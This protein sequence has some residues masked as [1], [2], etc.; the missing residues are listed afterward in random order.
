MDTQAQV[1]VLDDKINVRQRL[2][3]LADWQGAWK[4]QVA[5]LDQKIAAMGDMP[6]AIDIQKAVQIDSL[7][8]QIELQQVKI[9]LEISPEVI[10]A[11]GYSKLRQHLV[12]Q[13]TQL[14]KEERLF[15]LNNFLFI[16]TPQLRQLNIKIVQIRNYRSFGQQRNFLLGGYSGMGKTT[17]LD[18]FTSNY[19]PS[20]EPGRNHVPIIKIDA[21]EGK[22]VK[23][24]LQY[25]ILACGAN[26]LERDTEGKLM[27]KISFCFQKCGVEVLIVDEVEHIKYHSIRRRLLEV[28]NRTYHVPIIC[29]S[30]EPHVWVENDAEIA[31][32]WNDY[33]RLARYTS[34]KLKQLLAFLNL[35]LPFPK[36]S[37]LAAAPKK[38]VTTTEGIK[39]REDSSPEIAFVQQVTRGILKD[40]ML[41]IRCAS[42]EAV[43]QNLDCLKLD[44]LEKTWKKV[45]TQPLRS[46]A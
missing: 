34:E 23:E 21:P 10:G 27:N 14:S 42:I 20:V 4:A 7:R 33:F 29:A 9:P 22:S 38:N 26:F 19:I 12:K 45:Q 13:F 17:Y 11:L 41:L 32:R 18:W 43:E 31:G 3:Q 25:I 46:E 8:R 24:L 39:E 5:F 40:I 30:C 1:M 2:Q 36:D 16:M 6:K 37:L 44:L 35:I 15:W 28:S